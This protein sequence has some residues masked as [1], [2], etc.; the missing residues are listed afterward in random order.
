MVLNIR[1]L[2]D[3]RH[4]IATTNGFN[5]H[6]LMLVDLVDRMIIAEEKS[7]QSWFGLAV[8]KAES[9]VWWSGG[10]AGFLHQFDLKDRSW[11]RTSATETDATK[12]SREEVAALRDKLRNENAFRSG[13]LLD[14]TRQC[15][16]SLHINAGKLVVTSLADGGASERGAIGGRPY[17]C[18]LSIMDACCMCLTGQMLKSL[19]LNESLRVVSKI[20]VGF[21]PIKL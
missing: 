17:D 20:K 11:H 10:G 16:Y 19:S 1:P 2:A 21:T 3:N 9:K 4:A 18:S 8:N 5:D 13:I 14:E 12:L 15:L 7:L 6:K